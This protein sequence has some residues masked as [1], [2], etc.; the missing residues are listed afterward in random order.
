MREKN[1]AGRGGLR[2]RLATRVVAG[3]ATFSLVASMCP[4]A[5]ALAYANDQLA[6]GAADLEAQAEFQELALTVQ[7]EPAIAKAI[8]ENTH[9]LSTGAYAVTRDVTIEPDDSGNALQ[10][11]PGAR[12]TIIFMGENV[13]LTVTES[14]NYEAASPKTVTL[15]A[16]VK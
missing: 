9:R 7:G 4:G 13:K 8:T 1:A 16:N 10:V 11:D 3:I 12:V 14:A 2:A 15:T 6:A 5:M